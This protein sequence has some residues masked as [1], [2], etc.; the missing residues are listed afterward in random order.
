L[1]AAAEYIGLTLWG[2]RERIWSGQLPVIRFPGG[3][4]MYIDRQDI[5]QF[6]ERNKKVID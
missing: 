4:K 3:R 6:I 5:D 2:L 1:K